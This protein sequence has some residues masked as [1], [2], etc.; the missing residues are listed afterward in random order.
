MEDRGVETGT[1]MRIWAFRVTSLPGTPKA[2][3]LMS[4]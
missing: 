3:L 2:R 4:V 1:E